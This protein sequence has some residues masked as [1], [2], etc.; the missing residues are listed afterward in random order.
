[1]DPRQ[2]KDFPLAGHFQFSFGI[3]E[4]NLRG[5]RLSFRRLEWAPLS[6]GKDFSLSAL[7]P[8]IH[9]GVSSNQLDSSSPD[10]KSSCIGG[11]EQFEPPTLRLTREADI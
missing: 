5:L 3:E 6:T 9:H 1:M 4:K 8:R 10:Q 11:S 7:E 2:L